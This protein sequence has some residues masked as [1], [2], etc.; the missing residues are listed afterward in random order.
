MAK[1]VN[2]NRFFGEYTWDTLPTRYLSAYTESG[3]LKSLDMTARERAGKPL[4][5]G[6]S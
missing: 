2:I 5:G 1:N 3:K 4:P 6:D